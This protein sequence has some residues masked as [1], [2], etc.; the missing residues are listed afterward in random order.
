MKICGKFRQSESLLIIGEV[1]V[2][3]GNVQMDFDRESSARLRL[4][5]RLIGARYGI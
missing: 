3:R 5:L 2:F 4:P 1:Q